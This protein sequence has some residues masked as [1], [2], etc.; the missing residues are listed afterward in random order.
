VASKW[1]NKASSAQSQTVQIAEPQR[2]RKNNERGRGPFCPWT[3]PRKNSSAAVL[4]SNGFFVTHFE[5]TTISRSSSSVK[6]LG[7]IY[8][9]FAWLIVAIGMLHMLATFRLTSGSALGRVWFF[10][11]GLAIALV[12]ALNLLHR[13]YGRSCLGVRIV[14]RAANVLLTSLA[15]VAGTVTGTSV[16]QCCF[17]WLLLGGALILSCLPT[18][19]Q[20]SSFNKLSYSKRNAI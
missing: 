8:T 14:C 13:T 5:A 18:P 12:G 3:S 6:I 7:L 20:S 19:H 1:T 11:S 17:I 9:G 10:G 15:I 16:S 4:I 2:S